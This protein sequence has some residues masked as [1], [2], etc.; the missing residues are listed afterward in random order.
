M[1]LIPLKD[2]SERIGSGREDMVEIIDLILSESISQKISDIHF[3][4]QEDGVHYYSQA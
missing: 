1:V 2:L 3:K 4:T